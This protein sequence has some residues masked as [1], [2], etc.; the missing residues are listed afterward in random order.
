[1]N[2]TLKNIKRAAFAS[3]ETECF[4]A[5]IYIDGVRAGT[6]SNEGHGGPNNYSPHA[7]EGKLNAHAATMVDKVTQYTDN[8]G[9]RVV[10]S[11]NA[12]IL[13][14]DLLDDDRLLKQM[15]RDLKA[16]IIFTKANSAAIFQT[17][18]LPAPMLAKYL[19]MPMPVKDAAVILNRLPEATALAMYKVNSVQGLI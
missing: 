17:R 3:E 6:V 12:D 7:L 16:R 18:K 11:M 9:E 14:G 15:R 1:M 13:I 2:I 5:T 4:E 10:V 8:S 19:A